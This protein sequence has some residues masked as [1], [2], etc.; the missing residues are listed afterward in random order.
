MIAEKQCNPLAWRRGVSLFYFLIFLEWNLGNGFLF[1]CCIVW[2]HNLN[3]QDSSSHFYQ[4]TPPLVFLCCYP[5]EKTL[6]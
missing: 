2:S 4:K 6:W 1:S 5:V 3:V